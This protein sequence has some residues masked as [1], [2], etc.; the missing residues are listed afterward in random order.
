MFHCNMTSIQKRRLSQ[1]YSSMSF[2]RT[3]QCNSP[4]ARE[5]KSPAAQRLPSVSSLTSLFPPGQ[6]HS[7]LPTA[8]I[9]FAVLMKPG[10]LTYV[11][12]EF[13]TNVINLKLISKIQLQSLLSRGEGGQVF[14]IKIEK[15]Q[16]FISL[17]VVGKERKEKKGDIFPGFF[18]PCL[19]LPSQL[20]KG[21]HTK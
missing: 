19:P 13:I 9:S 2:H 18:P 17:I 21:A 15:N 10:I 16:I 20:P 1:A 14:I 8:Q 12:P 7:S 6:Q 3:H 5:T 4:Q 11:E